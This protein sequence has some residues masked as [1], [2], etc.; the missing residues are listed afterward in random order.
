[1]GKSDGFSFCSEL[2]GATKTAHVPVVLIARPDDEN[3]WNLAEVVGADEVIQKPAFA[4][5]VAAMV[6][7]E[8]SRHRAGTSTLLRFQAKAQSPALMLRALLASRRSGILTLADGTATVAFRR[9][10][11]VKARAGERWGVDALVRALMLT[12]QDY[13][14]SLE[15]PAADSDFTCSLKDYVT[16]VLPRLWKWQSLESRSLPFDAVLGVDFSQLA[17]SLPSLPDEVNRVVQLFDG[18][19]RV[20]DVLMDSPFDPTLT[21]EVATRLYLM[22]V[23]GPLQV[24]AEAPASKRAAPKLFE[25][26]TSSPPDDVMRRLFDDSVTSPPS[27]EGAALSVAPEW[28]VSPGEDLKLEDPVGGWQSTSLGDAQLA[29]GLSNDLANRLAAFQVATVVEPAERRASEKPMADFASGRA[30]ID[31]S[32]ESAVLQAVGDEDIVDNDPDPTPPSSR[33]M[34]SDADHQ[35]GIVTPVLTPVV[36]AEMAATGPAPSFQ[37]LAPLAGSDTEGVT[38]VSS[39]MAFAAPGLARFNEDAVL[40]ETTEGVVFEE[41]ETSSGETRLKKRSVGYLLAGLAVLAI[42]SAVGLE[43]LRTSRP[44]EPKVL[45]G[46]SSVSA[47]TALVEA[48]SSV[49]KAVEAPPVVEPAAPTAS[50]DDDSDLAPIVPLVDVSEPLSD[51]VRAYQRGEYKKALAILEQVVADDP[52]SVQAWLVLGQT[53]YDVNDVEG[54]KSAA[55]RVRELDPRNGQVH[56]LLATIAHDA[57]DRATMR[58]ELEAYLAVE[59]QGIHAAEAKALLAR[60]R[61]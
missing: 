55:V 31:E 35:F 34:F 37:T 4:R 41:S 22:G 25:P 39:S 21:M 17:T 26:A 33:R 48:P 19:R 10:V 40:D 59:P 1:L 15:M 51:G 43:S 61:P 36:R 28:S 2:R 11:I 3:V 12:A 8:L 52:R 14:L 45:E 46:A 47:G 32:L 44:A 5:D 18:H 13:T 53:R 7:V 50:G 23:I 54:A 56:I 42:L 16:Q 29:D 6:S 9:G 57:Q 60:N 38:S 27:S 58:Q 20:H 30:P 49:E 24:S